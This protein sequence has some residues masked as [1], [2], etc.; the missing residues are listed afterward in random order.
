MSW[1]GSRRLALKR[2]RPAQQVLSVRLVPGEQPEPAR[3]RLG[4]RGWCQRPPRSTPPS[5]RILHDPPWHGPRT[6]VIVSRVR[7]QGEAPD[8]LIHL[9]GHQD[10][11][12]ARRFAS[13]LELGDTEDGLLPVQATGHEYVRGERL[14]PVEYPGP[15]LEPAVRA[16]VQMHQLVRADDA[17]LKHFFLPLH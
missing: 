12:P 14:Q 3:R 5:R 11:N 13:Q 10:L 2:R 7:L 6:S 17:I 9:D 4:C 8:G 16:A 1:P 15:E